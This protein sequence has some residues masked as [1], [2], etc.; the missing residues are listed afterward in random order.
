MTQCFFLKS[1]G[2][3]KLKIA[4]FGK[5]QIWEILGEKF[6]ILGKSKRKNGEPGKVQVEIATTE[7]IPKKIYK[8]T[9]LEIFC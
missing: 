5:S 7:K 3:E 2:F 6:V 9:N 4:T 1:G 8:N